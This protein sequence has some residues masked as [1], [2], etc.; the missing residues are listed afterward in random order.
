MLFNKEE[1]HLILRIFVVTFVIDLFRSFKLFNILID[2]YRTKKSSL[3]MKFA[4]PAGQP[5]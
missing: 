4:I 1:F 3:S 2:R 5:K